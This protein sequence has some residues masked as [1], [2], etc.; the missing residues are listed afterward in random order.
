MGAA[1]VLMMA[2][3]GYHMVGQLK[4]G[5]AKPENLCLT[6]PSSCPLVG[7]SVRLVGRSARRRDAGQARHDVRTDGGQ[8][9]QGKACLRV[10]SGGC[11]L[12]SSTP[13][14][15]LA[16]ALLA[17]PRFGVGSRGR[18]HSYVEL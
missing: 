17:R 3:L 9:A 14:A 1:L 18:A 16:A 4:A 6:D 8:H 13:Q 5:Q 12:L 7:R 10:P 15:T 2:P 11:Q